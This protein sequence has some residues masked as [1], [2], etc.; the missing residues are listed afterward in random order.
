VVSAR[1]TMVSHAPTAA[2][3]TAAFAHLDEP[4][5]ARGQAWAEAARGR[6]DRV[7]GAVCSPALACR[8]TAAALAVSALVEPRIRDWEL[9]SWRG[10]TFD[11]V[12]ADDP[13]AIE[14][15][16]TEPGAA[17]H[18]G[19]PL[20]GLLSRVGDWLAAVPPDGHTAAITHPAV[21]RAAVISTLSGAAAGFWR[22]DIAPLTATEFRGGPGR[23]TLR[24]TGLPLGRRAIT[25]G[26][27]GPGD[28]GPGDR[29]PAAPDAAADR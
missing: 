21:V 20:A 13:T 19:E 28:R 14:A 4:L 8:Q 7:T 12:A 11:Q 5:D 1:L 9:G 26:S 22:I 23:W 24:S 10:R 2:T 16:L 15:W 29:G 3:A 6:I 18:G 25:G 17:P 27:V